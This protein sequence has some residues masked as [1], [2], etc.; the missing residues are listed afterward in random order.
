MK[1]DLAIF[2]SIYLQ[3]VSII[4]KRMWQ[5]TQSRADNN[6]RYS[7][8]YKNRQMGSGSNLFASPG[9]ILGSRR[10]AP[11]PRLLLPS[12]SFKKRREASSL[13]YWDCRSSTL[14]RRRA[15][16]RLRRRRPFLA[17]SNSTF[18]FDIRESR[19]SSRFRLQP[20]VGGLFPRVAPKS[21]R[22]LARSLEE[23]DPRVTYK[24]VGVIS[25]SELTTT[26]RGGDARAL[27]TCMAKDSN[28]SSFGE[29][30]WREEKEGER[31]ER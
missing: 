7:R 12:A 11:P 15:L 20:P 3:F 5:Y 9:I 6:H 8:G 28:V 4:F 24:G 31:E 21:P 29:R 17:P 1:I 22:S 27:E 16:R 18:Q 14:L 19:P 2:A 23:A 10:D 25:K 30:E 26:R 13:S